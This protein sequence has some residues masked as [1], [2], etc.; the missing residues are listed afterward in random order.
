MTNDQNINKS[1]QDGKEE[2]N[3]VLLVLWRNINISTLL[4]L[5]LFQA[6]I[7]MP[8]SNKAGNPHYPIHYMCYSYGLIKCYLDKSHKFL[9]ILFHKELA[10]S[11][12]NLIKSSYYSY[13]DRLIDSKVFHNI[14]NNDDLN[15]IKVTLKIPNKFISDIDLISKTSK[16]THTSKDFKKRMRPF[17]TS[18]PIITH[19]VA[20]Y[21]VKKAIPY[22]IVIKANT[23][24]KKIMSLFNITDVEAE[25]Y[26]T[27][28]ANKEYWDQSKYDLYK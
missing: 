6:E 22:S 5:K 18:I 2:D 9:H 26:I 13:I 1:S 21:I 28:D 4:F 19:T 11:D 24:K 16:Y 17:N 15:I 3:E 7:K 10:I 23:L 25:Y 20:R 14:E 8:Y 27:F 12:L